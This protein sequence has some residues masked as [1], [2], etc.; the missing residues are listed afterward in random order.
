MAR[1]HSQK[2]FDDLVK[3]FEKNKSSQKI[4]AEVLDELAHR[5][6]NKKI[7]GLMNNVEI[8]IKNSESQGNG[9][10]VVINETPKIKDLQ[11]HCTSSNPLGQS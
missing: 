9:S 6:K 4:L 7:P 8:A 3:I 1:P 10:E 2:S 5:K 11:L